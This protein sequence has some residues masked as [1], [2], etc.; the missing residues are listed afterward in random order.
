MDQPIIGEPGSGLAPRMRTVKESPT[1]AISNKVRELVAAGKDI[2]NLGEGELDFDTPDHV[3]SIGIDAIRSGDTKYTAVGGTEELKS[4]IQRKFQQENGLSYQ[5][6]QIIAATGAKQI[7]FNAILATVSEG[8]EVITPTPCWVSYPD[9]VGLAGGKP[10]YV[11]CLEE[12]GFKLRP[13]ALEAVITPQT[14]WIILN[15]PNNPSGA[16]YS[17]DQLVGLANVLLRYPHVMA[18]VDDIYEHIVFSFK[19]STLAEVEPRLMD[20]VLTVNGVSKAY[21]MTGWR[22]GYAGGPAWLIQAIDILQSQSTGNACSITQAAAVAALE[23]SLDFFVPRLDALSQ[24][25]QKIMAAI[26][27]T[28]GMLSCQPPDGAFYVFA[29]CQKM[30]G[31]KMPS[32]GIIEND[33][34]CASYLLDEAGLAMVPGVAFGMSPYIRIA[35]AI[36]D[37]RLDQACER[38]VAA[39]SKLS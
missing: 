19:A 1:A 23:G 4:A 18:L 35:Y 29:N 15:N 32:G 2:I 12:D 7:I 38:L 25:R 5:H 14:K 24:R 8:D 9:I 30:I 21:S 27:A 17:R 10:V 11:E 20:R 33:V 28:N 26:E 36:D 13:D 31:A 37:E 39:I 22:L 34:D 3:K 6:D 16:V